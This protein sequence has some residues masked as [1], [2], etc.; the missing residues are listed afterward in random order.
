MHVVMRLDISIV[1]GDL[2]D[3]NYNDMRENWGETVTI[4]D[5]GYDSNGKVASAMI[6]T[7]TGLWDIRMTCRNDNTFTLDNLMFFYTPDPGDFP[8]IGQTPID[9]E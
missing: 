8:Q 3:K 7:M 2:T 5:F 9:A 6:V 4:V 1:G